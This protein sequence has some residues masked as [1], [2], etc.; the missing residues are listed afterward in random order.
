MISGF[1]YVSHQVADLERARAFYQ[2]VLGLKSQGSYAGTWEEYDVGGETFAVWKV[3]EITPDY[4]EKEK[5]TASIAF[6]V[7]DI[8][9]FC[10][11]LKKAGVNFL[12]EPVENDGHCI[13]AYITD[14]DGNIIT[15][16]QLL[17]KD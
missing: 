15:L 13:T 6:E 4:F 11:K 1:A 16:H 12:Q 2:G 7:D 10:R 8:E 5:V 14:P 17:E 3:S 9:Q